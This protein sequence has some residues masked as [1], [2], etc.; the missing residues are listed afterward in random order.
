MYEI[1]LQ[2]FD[3]Q[4]NMDSGQ[5]FR[6]YRL[7]D[8]S[9]LTLSGSRGVVLRREGDK[10][11]FSCTPEEFRD[12]W[13]AYFDLDTDYGAV[14]RSIDPADSYLRAAARMGSGVRILRQDLWETIIGF[15]IS[16][17][18]NITR[19]RRSMDALSRRFGE[20]LSLPCLPPGITA[21]AFPTPEALCSGGPDGLSGLGLGYRDR[22][23]FQMAQRCT[24]EQ[25]RQWLEKLT[26][27]SY[28]DASALLMQEMGIGRKVAD[29]I[30]LFA[31]HHVDA[32]PVDTHVRQILAAH[33]P[34]GFP[35]RRYQGYAGILQQYMF[36]YELNR[37]KKA[38][39]KSKPDPVLRCGE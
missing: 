2:D 5:V 30:C 33:Y 17:N 32:F 10:T 3:I 35:F 24:G 20:P 8:D 38:T 31:L 27:C 28:T 34:D 29:C 22:Y 36:Y 6:I 23:V 39:G 21:H 25:G 7:P 16:Q 9:F 18:N 14:M 37:K 19:I 26:R 12:Y 4:M 15:L 13:H 11:V 1:T